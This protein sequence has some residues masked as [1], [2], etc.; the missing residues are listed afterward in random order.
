MNYRPVWAGF[1]CPV[2]VLTFLIQGSI[3]VSRLGVRA[4][5][6]L[7]C[8]PNAGLEVALRGLGEILVA[9]TSS[10]ARIRI[11]PVSGVPQH[12]IIGF[13]SGLVAG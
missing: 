1:E 3:L 6:F 10:R 2:L 8:L 7:L 11:I 9:K 4:A 12:C 5:R 13:G